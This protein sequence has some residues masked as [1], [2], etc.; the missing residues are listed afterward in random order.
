[1]SFFATRDPLLS[2]C[3]TKDYSVF[4][5]IKFFYKGSTP[6]HVALYKGY[7][8]LEIGNESLQ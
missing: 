1:M 3:A 5:S 8:H 4:T 7:F 6:D 2:S